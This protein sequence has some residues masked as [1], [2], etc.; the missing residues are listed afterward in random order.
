MTSFSFSN[1]MVC[2]ASLV[3]AGSVLAQDVSVVLD[4]GTLVTINAIPTAMAAAVT[5]PA[6]AMSG[7][8][9]GAA[10]TGFP[11]Y[12][13]STGCS[14]TTA[15]TIAIP[16]P[17]AVFAEGEKASYIVQF[18]DNSYTGACSAAYTLEPGSTVIAHKK[19][20]LPSPGCK[21]GFVYVATFTAAVPAK[22]GATTLYGSVTGGTEKVTAHLA[23]TI[24]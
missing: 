16:I 9:A 24:Q 19:L 11:C 7:L 20:S 21:P 6:L 23:I 4:D 17:A 15:N 12:G 8:T 2:A 3:F 5:A 18:Q 13:G 10:V 1:L 22:P 14:D